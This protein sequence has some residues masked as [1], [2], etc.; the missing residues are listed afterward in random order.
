MNHPVEQKY[1]SL[2]VRRRLG[3]TGYVPRF[4]SLNR[5]YNGLLGAVL[6]L[7][8]APLL[9]GFALV[10]RIAQGPGVLVRASRLGQD[11]QAFDVYRFATVGQD[12]LNPMADR[13]LRPTPL[14]VYLRETGL[15]ALP[16]LLNVVLGDMNICGP[17]PV[18]SAIAQ[19][20]EARDPLYGTRFAVKPGLISFTQ[21]VMGPGANQRVRGKLTYR[22]CRA[23][24]NVLAEWRLMVQISVTVLRK[25]VRQWTLGARQAGHLIRARRKAQDLNIQLKTATGTFPVYALSQ[26][27]LTTPHVVTGGAAQIIFGVGKGTRK[28][29]VE[30]GRLSHLQGETVFQYLAANENAAHLISRYLKDEATVGPRRPDWQPPRLSDLQYELDLHIARETVPVGVPRR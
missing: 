15:D 30:L 22:L 11:R 24:V 19:I 18:R 8:L 3:Q 6:L 14:G 27:L 5:I 13:N 21:A 12:R 26:S 25:T 4:P 23:P 1:V 2:S 17:H 29:R 28:A 9:L 7:A 16:Q 20:E 10:L